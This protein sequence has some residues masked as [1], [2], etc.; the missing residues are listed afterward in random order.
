MIS[1]AID[2]PSG[3]GKSTL[4]KRL[5]SEMG[6][7]YVD[8]GAM[9]RTIGLF[10][11]RQNVDPKDAKNVSKLLPEL[12]MHFEN[13]SGAQKIFLG[14]E[15]V[16]EAIRKEEI[17]MA[18]SAVSAIPEVRAHLLDLQRQLAQT[19][20]VVMDGR[21]IGTVILPNATVKIY[22]TASSTARATRRLLE[23]EQKGENANFETVLSDI[24][25]RDY[26]DMNRKIAPLKQADDA[27]LLDTSE[28]TFDESYEKLSAIVKTVIARKKCD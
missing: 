20:N 5:T 6:Y 10:A 1:I 11:L 21:D 9:Y 3:A 4:A 13:I 23:L 25:Q 2:G 24:E 14:A 28:L 18:A 19:Q 12:E 22:L 15:D 27:L 8:T 7:I 16:S 26:Q 17:G